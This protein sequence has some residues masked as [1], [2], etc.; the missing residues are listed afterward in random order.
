[1]TFGRVEGKSQRGNEQTFL[2]I[3]FGLGHSDSLGWLLGEWKD[4]LIMTAI[5]CN[6]SLTWLTLAIDANLSH[7][8]KMVTSNIVLSLDNWFLL[9]QSYGRSSRIIEKY[10]V[11]HRAN[12]KRIFT[13]QYAYLPTIPMG[14]EDRINGSKTCIKRENLYNNI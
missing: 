12:L 2:W 6:N 7:L 10:D 13:E 8:H 11:T 4:K 9:H 3:I 14:G 5:K 1:M